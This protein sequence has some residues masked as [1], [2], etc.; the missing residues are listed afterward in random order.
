MARKTA[1]AGDYDDYRDRQAGISRERSA[2]GREIGPLPP[3]ADP[4]RKNA[5]LDS[6]A[7]F[8]RSYFPAWFPLPFSGAHLDAIDRL[9]RCSNDGGLF[10]LAM[11]RGGGKTTLAKAAVLRAILYGLRRFVVLVQATQPLAVRSLKSIQRELESND[12]LLADFPEV[13]Y[14]VRKLGRIHNRA[15]GQTLAG[16]PTRIEWTVDGVILPTVRGSAASGAVIHVAGITG[17][18]KGL[19]VSGPAGELLRPDMA[20]ID[21]A[22]TRESAK[23]PTQTADREAVICE[24]VLGLAGPTTTIAAVNVCTPIYPNDLSERFLDP[25][26][27]PEWKGVRRK[28]LERMPDRMD[29]WDRY[30]EVRRE[31]FRAGGDGGEATA[32]YAEHREEM[33]RGSA[34]TWPERKKEGELSG[35]QSA[36][37]LYYDNPRGFKAE[38]QCEP[39]AG[40]LGAAAK[41]LSA[42]AIAARL[43][44]TERYQVPRECTRL[45][46]GFDCG[47]KLLWYLVAAWTESGGGTVIDYGCW[48][49]QA[50]SQFA[51]ADARPALA[52]VYAGHTE[53]QLVFA[54]LKDLTAEVLGR[55]YHREGGGEVR[56]ERG[57]VDSGWQTSAVY[58]LVRASALGGVLLPSKGVGRTTTARGVGEWRPRPGER[59]GYH[60][61]LSAGEAGRGRAV[62][63]DPDPW[64]SLLHERLTTPPGGGTALTLF[65]RSAAAHALVGEHLAA[66][67][68]T[69]VTIRGATFDKWAPRP[70]RPDNHLLDC[71]VLAAVA[72]SVLGLKLETATV[73]GQPA[74]APKGPTGRL[75]DLQARK[76]ASAGTGGSGRPK[77]S[78]IQAR[79]RARAGR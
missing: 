62:Q 47:A 28:M 36:M 10:A 54:G 49:R 6:L 27:R 76:L 75:S 37:N 22:Q 3:V 43:S 18:L 42:E 63:F 55:T 26:R 59:K 70:N 15:K 44:G 56:V 79:N 11:M 4:A 72:A 38:Y 32:C 77:L 17:A 51:A 14:P 46:A 31:S 60:W 7:A 23:S 45:T 25:D 71:A 73:S 61:R 69:P 13:C 64:K 20:V 34:V 29:L 48:P 74:A 9:E 30:A 16:E 58:Q 24:D 21:D 67:Y 19:N 39:E 50:R 68:S 57:L 2:A 52:D 5:G 65:G 35:L 66:E 78:E 33:D 12:L 53:S 1:T 41:E 40:D 8:C